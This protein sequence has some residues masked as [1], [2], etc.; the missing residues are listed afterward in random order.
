[1]T[2]K[3]LVSFSGGRTSAYMTWWLMNEWPERDN[4]DLKVVFANTGKELIETLDF[5]NE[6]DMR[7]NLG[8]I[9]VEAVIN[10][11]MGTGTTHKVVSYQTASRNGEPFEAMISKY[12]IPNAAFPHCTRELKSAPIHHYIKNEIGWKDY[13]TAIGIR[14]DEFDRMNE[15]RKAYKFRYPLVENN[16]TLKDI[17]IFWSKQAFDLKIESYEGNCDLCWKKSVPKLEKIC[18]K[19]PQSVEW[20][21]VMEETYG[22]FIPHTRVHN[23]KIVPPI[24]FYR[25]SKS[26]VDFVNA[27]KKKYTQRDLFEFGCSESCEPF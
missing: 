9:W 17:S 26:I 23:T 15:N 11:G 24:R 13:Y 5:V 20:W 7:W 4:W 16:I 18:K 1:M 3:L 12:G 21:R 6:C 25:D 14:V 27:P 8:V 10:S 22:N 2:P 19:R